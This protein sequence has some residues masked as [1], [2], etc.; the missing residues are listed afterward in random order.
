M[1]KTKKPSSK[2]KDSKLCLLAKA[3]MKPCHGI[4]CVSPSL[5]ITGQVTSKKQHPAYPFTKAP[6]NF[7][8]DQLMAKNVI[9]RPPPLPVVHKLPPLTKPPQ[10]S[11]LYEF[12]DT[13]STQTQGFKL[14][15][16]INDEPTKSSQST[17][18]EENMSMFEPTMVGFKDSD[19]M[20]LDKTTKFVP[21]KVTPQTTAK[22][23]LMVSKQSHVLKINIK[24]PDVYSRD[25][26]SKEKLNDK[27]KQ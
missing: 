20:E 8:H 11:T 26:K 18:N 15:D 21:P 14:A 1:E 3:N 24:L 23:N 4:G 10:N 13:K 12:D 27:H 16:S 17:K 2:T 5:M 22:G 7:K 9:L 6:D 25:E 19:L